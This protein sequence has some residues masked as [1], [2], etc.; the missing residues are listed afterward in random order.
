[1]GT[2]KLWRGELYRKRTSR[3][4]ETPIFTDARTNRDNGGPRKGED[5]LAHGKILAKWLNF[6]I[7]FSGD[8]RASLQ[9]L[10][11]VRVT[12]QLN[13]KDLELRFLV[14]KTLDF[15]MNFVRVA[16]ETCHKW[17]AKRRQL[18][19]KSRTIHFRVCR[20]KKR[21]RVARLKLRTG[22]FL[23][24]RVVGPTLGLASDGGGNPP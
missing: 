15:E 7:R 22:E 9:K 14:A 18:A 6:R 16:S 3:V 4:V 21:L 17:R 13:A 19:S 11:C 5:Y 23:V 1:M 2:Q 12:Q 8:L 20:R 10:C 24:G